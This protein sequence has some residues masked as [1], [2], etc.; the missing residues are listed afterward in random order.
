MDK[1]KEARKAAGLSRYEMAEMF[2][3]PYKTLMNW[4]TDVRKPPAY[5]EKLILEKLESMKKD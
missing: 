1:I 2:E 5:V 3:I 4:E